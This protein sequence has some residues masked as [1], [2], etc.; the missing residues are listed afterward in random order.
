MSRTVVDFFSSD[1]DAH[2]GDA[3]CE[4]QL[5]TENIMYCFQC[6]DVV[7]NALY[8]IATDHCC[9]ISWDLVV[10]TQ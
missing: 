3:K 2:P 4:R 9:C 10:M 1:N 6:V 5:D 7:V 8:L